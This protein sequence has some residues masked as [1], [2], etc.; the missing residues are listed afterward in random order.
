M[1]VNFEF[2]SEPLD[3]VSSGQQYPPGLI[4]SYPLARAIPVGRARMHGCPENNPN[5][6]DSS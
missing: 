4:E 3:N 6:I 1:K 5:R 2:R